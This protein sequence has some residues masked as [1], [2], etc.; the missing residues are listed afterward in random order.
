MT[1]ITAPTTASASVSPVAWAI[2]A[3]ALVMFLLGVALA[4]AS[5]GGPAVPSHE[6]LQNTTPIYIDTTPLS[7]P[8]M[9]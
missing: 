7:G 8:S 6:L 3:A 1:S 2:L 5:M 4:V 9:Y